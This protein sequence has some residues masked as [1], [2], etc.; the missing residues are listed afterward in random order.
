MG[1]G[2]PVLVGRAVVVRICW[3]LEA[4]FKVVGLVVVVR[5][6]YSN[7]H[8]Q[9]ASA[10]SRASL[11]VWWLWKLSWP[12]VLWCWRSCSGVWVVVALVR[13]LCVSPQVLLLDEPFSALDPKL[14]SQLQDSLLDLI[15][16]TGVSVVMVTHDL[17]EALKIGDVILYVNGEPAQVQLKVRPKTADSNEAV[18][19]LHRLVKG[20]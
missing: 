19:R 18:A 15:R 10:P 13:G 3:L 1:A 4:G 16:F 17:T 12:G 6:C 20:E 7:L 11:G 9:P 5:V 2:G 8:C 14:R